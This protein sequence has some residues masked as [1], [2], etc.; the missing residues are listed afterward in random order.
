MILLLVVLLLALW[1]HGAARVGDAN[2]AI[3]EERG[4]SYNED[5]AGEPTRD[6]CGLAL[7][8]VLGTVA[9]LTL[10]GALVPTP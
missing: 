9:A 7:L 4:E 10:L 2:A 8:T 1:W 3:K 6:G 5:A